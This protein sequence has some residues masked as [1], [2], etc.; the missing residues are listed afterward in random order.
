M[1]KQQQLEIKR[2][3]DAILDKM[4]TNLTDLRTIASGMGDELTLQN[5]MLTGLNHDVTTVQGNMDNANNAV[6]RVRGGRGGPFWCYVL[7]IA[8]LIITILVLVYIIL[9]STK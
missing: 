6:T 7:W 4:S 5:R 9:Q 2:E 8:A 1:S 3:Q